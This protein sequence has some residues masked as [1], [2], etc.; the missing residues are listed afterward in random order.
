[1]RYRVQG[2]PTILLFHS[3]D[4]RVRET[5]PSYFRQLPEMIAWVEKHCPK[6]VEKPKVM[7]TIQTCM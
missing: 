3:K 1:M 7:E 4:V 5:L 2:F 6:I